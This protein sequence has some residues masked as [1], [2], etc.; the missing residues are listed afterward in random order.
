MKPAAISFFVLISNVVFS[1]NRSYTAF[2]QLD[3]SIKWA[4]E[5]DKV[6]N[7]SPKVK[8]YSLKKWYIDKLKTGSVTA[9]K[10]N[11]ET[12]VLSSYELSMPGLERQEWLKDLSVVPGRSKKPQ[13]W[14]VI[15]KI[16]KENDQL[17]TYRAGQLN[18]SADSCCGCDESDAFRAKQIITYKN[19][20]FDIYT[21]F[22]SPLCLR[23]TSERLSD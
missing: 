4:A 11:N 7:L 1:Q 17:F 2:I 19:A 5:C 14:Y 9:Y 12:R 16:K 10:I 20:R 3:T 13:D 18:E 23:K 6:I 15:D 22:I 21:V 8:D